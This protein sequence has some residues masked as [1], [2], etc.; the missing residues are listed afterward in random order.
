MDITVSIGVNL[1]PAK[2]KNFEEAFK[3][4]DKALY[5]AKDKGR[6][7]I[8]IYNEN[9]QVHDDNKLSINEIKEALD[10]KRVFCFYQKV[11]D[12]YTKEEIFS[13]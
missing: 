12:T 1:Q 11:V 13:E 7:N 9:S 2:S 3:L 4:A 5:L 8:Q 10:E 6:N